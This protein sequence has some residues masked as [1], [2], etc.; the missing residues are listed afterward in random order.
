MYPTGLGQKVLEVNLPDKYREEDFVQQICV[1]IGAELE[2]L[3]RW[4]NFEDVRDLNL[5]LK[6]Q[7]LYDH[8]GILAQWFSRTVTGQYIAWWETMLGIPTDTTLSD[9]NRRNNIRARM[10]QRANAPTVDFIQA[11]VQQYVTSAAV[12]VN[13]ATYSFTI[14]II[15]PRAALPATVQNN[16]TA[17]VEAAKP[18]HL[19]YT[20]L[21]SEEDWLSL[22]NRDWL[23]IGN[24]DWNTINY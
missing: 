18:S 20:I 24:V 7:Y 13:I 17:A 2:Q 9:Q 8:E 12:S 15:L 23:T 11:Q 22:Q 3:D 4:I 5:V 14:K 16:I 6:G 10:S 19:G 21:F 1:A